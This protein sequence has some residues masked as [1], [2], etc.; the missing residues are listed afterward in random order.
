M[1]PHNRSAAVGRDANPRTAV[2]SRHG[3][4]GAAARAGRPGG[5]M[6]TSRPT[7][8]GPHNETR[9]WS[10]RGRRGMCGV[11]HYFLQLSGGWRMLSILDFFL[12]F[13]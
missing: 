1:A 7:A 4:C 6:G 9:V 2:A 8:T 10:T 5:A 11:R 12:N 3:Q 13:Y